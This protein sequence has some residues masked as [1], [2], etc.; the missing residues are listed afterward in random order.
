[1]KRKIR[2]AKKLLPVS[3]LQRRR[4]KIDVLAMEGRMSR[5]EADAR[6]QRLD[7]LIAHRS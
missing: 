7:K 6:I 4:A 1:M 5:H 2:K 3:E